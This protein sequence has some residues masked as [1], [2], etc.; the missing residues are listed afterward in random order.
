MFHVPQWVNDLFQRVQLAHARSEAKFVVPTADL[1]HLLDLYYA[2]EEEIKDLDDEVAELVRERDAAERAERGQ[3]GLYVKDAPYD[4][5]YCVGPGWR[6]ILERLFRDLETLGF[7]GEVTQVKEKYGTLR[8]YVSGV[9]EANYEAVWDRINAAEKES[10][11]VCEDCGAPG[12]RRSGGWLRT[13][14][15]GCHRPEVAG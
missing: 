4:W 8:V 9:T 15:G 5:V 6:G 10:E 14:C 1:V 11:S 13:L 7:E 3:T 12:K 2:A